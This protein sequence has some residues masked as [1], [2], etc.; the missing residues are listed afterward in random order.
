MGQRGARLLL[1]LAWACL[2]VRSQ[3]VGDQTPPLDEP[4]ALAETNRE[5]RYARRHSA[6]ASNPRTP[7][8]PV[9]PRPHGPVDTGARWRI[10]VVRSGRYL[11]RNGLEV[12]GTNQFFS[13]FEFRRTRGGAYYIADHA[14]KWLHVGPASASGRGPS[15]QAIDYSELDLLGPDGPADP[16]PGLSGKVAPSLFWLEEQ[17]GG[18]YALKLSADGKRYLSED[19]AD[20]RRLVAAGGDGGWLWSKMSNA[21]ASA[22]ALFHLERV[23]GAPPFPSGGPQH[24]TPKPCRTRAPATR[25]GCPSGS[26][27]GSTRIT[28]RMCLPSPLR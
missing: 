18:A 15:L 26:H 28:R 5:H 4:R 20:P 16:M 25:P 1:V 13:L 11:Y 23:V 2:C 9:P 3:L 14:G 21:A 8:V 27:T 19:A 7:E 10:E 24:D 12:I 17:A 22:K 6:A